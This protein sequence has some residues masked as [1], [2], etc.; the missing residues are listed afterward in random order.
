MA[1][2]IEVARPLPYSAGADPQLER[3]LGEACAEVARRS[4]PGETEL[5]GPR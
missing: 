1:P 5:A 3:A 2:D 4:R